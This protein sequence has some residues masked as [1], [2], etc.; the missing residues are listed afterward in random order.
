MPSREHHHAVVDKTMG[1]PIDLEGDLVH[2]L[3][4]VTTSNTAV[5]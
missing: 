1:N 5:E 2:R 4:L 3:E